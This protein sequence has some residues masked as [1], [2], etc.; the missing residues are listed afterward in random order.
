MPSYDHMSWGSPELDAYATRV[1]VETGLPI[2]VA[3]VTSVGLPGMHACYDPQPDAI[4]TQVLRGADLAH[5]DS[6]YDLAHELTHGLLYR[7]RG[8]LSLGTV[9]RASCEEGQLAT[10]LTTMVDDIVVAVALQGQGFDPV[11]ATYF[12]ETVRETR[13]T[14]KR[15]D[16]LAHIDEGPAFKSRFLEYRC[17]FAWGVRTHCRLTD[18]QRRVIDKFLQAMRRVHPQEQSRADLV[19]EA[20]SRHDIFTPEGHRLA[21]EEVISL[22]GLDSVARLFK[23][24]RPDDGAAS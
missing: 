10:L 22:W 7:S 15:I 9:S 21:V 23:V 1:E 6:E 24:R 4:G 13:A 3:W 8:F 5:P 2:K 19:V 14:N 11:P 20:L 17:V 16:Y 18:Y 12:R